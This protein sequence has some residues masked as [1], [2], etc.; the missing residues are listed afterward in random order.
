VTLPQPLPLFPLQSVL[1]PGGDLPLRIF[2]PRYLDMIARCHREG[3]PFGVVGLIEGSEVR[4]RDPQAEDGRFA[5]EA[6]HPVGTH[7]HIEL[8]E[9]SQP[10]L[11]QIRCRGGQRFRLADFECLPHGLWVGSGE[12][13]EPD[14]VVPVPPDLARTAV[15]LQGLLHTLQQGAAA[16]DVPLQPPYHW[17]D[18]GWLANRWCELLPLPAGERQRLMQLENPLLRLELVADQLERLGVR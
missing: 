6:F 5:R 14:V 17:D 13:L 15:L 12:L 18:S 10:G 4:R 9:R 3:T 16:A 7:A 1:F 11:I 2:E 8:F